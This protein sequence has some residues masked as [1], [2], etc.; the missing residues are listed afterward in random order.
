MPVFCD[1][2][3]YTFIGFTHEESCEPRVATIS[4]KITRIDYIVGI[5]KYNSAEGETFLR[6]IWMDLLLFIFFLA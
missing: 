3:P 5:R 6:N 1:S 4:E 2:P